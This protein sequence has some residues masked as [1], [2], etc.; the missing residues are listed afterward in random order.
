MDDRT[1]VPGGDLCDADPVTGSGVNVA[2]GLIVLAAASS[3]TLA[4]GFAELWSAAA[5]LTEQF[6]NLREGS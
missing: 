4:Q 6:R 2:E 5:R 1:S 3:I